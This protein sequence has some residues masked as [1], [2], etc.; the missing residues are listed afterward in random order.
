MP[1]L[2]VRDMVITGAADRTLLIV[3]QLHVP[4]G[5]I[6]LVRGP[7][8]AGK[9]TLLFALSGLM[10][11]ASGS[12][13]WGNQEL[14]STSQTARARFRRWSFGVIFQDNLLFD[15]LPADINA[16][17]SACYAPRPRRKAVQK[18]A[19]QAL[20]E[21][22]VPWQDRRDVSRFSG[23]ERQ[24]IAVARALASDP[25]VILADEPTASL[26]RSTAN[27][28]I[29]E[30]AGATKQRRRTLIVVSHDPAFLEVAD[31]V[32]MI[33]DGKMEENRA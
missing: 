32:V 29:A 10:P 33:E 4:K 20:T 15:E 16:A 21:F 27:R 24:R 3:S 8:G 31:Q 12:L 13:K 5:E 22:H 26:D 25:P 1:D 18:A 14:F 2:T 7:S 28:L 11:V 17:L 30:L 19:E 23:G 9:S 6:L